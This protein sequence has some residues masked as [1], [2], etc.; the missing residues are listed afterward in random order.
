[1]TYYRAAQSG[2][3]ALAVCAAP[4]ALAAEPQNQYP[5]R[6]VRMVVGFAAGGATDLFARIVAQRLTERW[7][8]QIVVDNRTGAGGSLGTAIVAKAQPDGYTLAVISSSHMINASLYKSLPFDPI[9]DFDGVAMICGI[10]NVLAVNPSLPA[11]SVTEFIALAKTKPGA[12][13]FASGGVGSSS[14]LAGE[15]FKSMA[16]IQ[17]VHVPYKGTAD[18][19]RDL[20]SGQVQSTV[21]AVSALLPHINKGALRALGVGDLRRMPQLP[22]VPTI[23]ESGLPGFEYA[24]IVGILAP[25][26]TPREVVANLNRE[27]SEILN[28]PEIGA[29]FAEMGARPALMTPQQLNTLVK[30][31]VARFA[32]II[33]SAG[34]QTQ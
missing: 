23:A 19:L 28:T 31:D 7:G 4:C 6:P 20:I 12:I 22:D 17:I 16:G 2:L 26:R 1:M 18:A 9:A 30:N 10:T 33:K 24:A 14:H 29:R 25:A 5:T 13:N 27:I 8:Q 32:R 15:L 34:V 11:K 21:D 3:L